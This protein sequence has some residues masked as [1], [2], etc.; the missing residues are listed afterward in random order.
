MAPTLN[1]W[2]IEFMQAHPRLSTPPCRA[3]MPSLRR[4]SDGQISLGPAARKASSS[5]TPLATNARVAA[6]RM[7]CSPRPSTNCPTNSSRC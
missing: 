4:I 3:A 5:T 6:R 2:R 7:W 1:N